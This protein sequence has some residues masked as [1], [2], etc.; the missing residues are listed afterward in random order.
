MSER[1]VYRSRID[2]PA[3]EVFAWHERPGA[4]ERL[5]P[6][7]ESV[8]VI[9]RTG[10][11]RDGDRVILQT[12]VGPVAVRWVIEHRDYQAGRQFRDVQITGPFSRW[13]HTHLVEADGA[14]AWLEDRIEYALPLGALGRELAGTAIRRRLSRMFAY[15]HRVTAD[16][17]AGRG[18]GRKEPSM[19]VVVSGSSGLIGSNLVPYLRTCGDQVGRLSRRSGGGTDELSVAWDPARGTID[20]AR[21]EGVDGVVHL[22]GE[23]IAGRWTP[24]K[25]RMIRESRVAGTRLLAETLAGLSRR[26]RV[27]VC[28]SAIGIYGDRG[29]ELLNE[30]S[31][32]GRGFLADVVGEWEA[33][34]EPALRAGIR[35]VQLRFGVVLSPAGGALAKMLTP[36][37]LGGGGVVGSGRQFMSWIAIDDALGAV[38]HALLTESLSG[39]VNAVAPLAVTNHEFTKTLG[40]VM[41]R[42]TIASMPAFA[43]R[44]AFGEMAEELLL[45]S[46]RVEPSRLLE[47]GYRFRF[48]RLEEALRHV[49]GRTQAA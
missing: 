39:A 11:I 35:V 8:Q 20:S 5:Q 21:L 49:L 1:F 33:A 4:F 34:A 6:P 30:A 44:L 26:P 17:L 38:R 32:A 18:A 28:A 10:G 16:D 40:R 48:V 12:R 45:A 31:G 37:S 22:A 24:E 15:R 14:G 42:P 7:W 41:R 43:A 19:N 23:P 9:Q 47:T 46:A 3:E 36:F 25:K 13:E 29:E 2:A 27:L